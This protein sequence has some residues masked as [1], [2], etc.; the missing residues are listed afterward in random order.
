VTWPMIRALSTTTSERDIAT[1]PYPNKVVL[2]VTSLWMVVPVGWGLLQLA[3]PNPGEWV[4]T[5]CLALVCAASTAFWRDPKS[6][7]WLHKLDKGLA[8]VFMG[9]MGWYSRRELEALPLVVCSIVC[10]FLLS[11]HYFQHNMDAEQLAAHLMFRY[12]SYW[13]AYFCIVPS[14]SELAFT[15]MSVVY[16]SHAFLLYDGLERN[17]FQY[18]YCTHCLCMLFWIGACVLIVY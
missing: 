6:G 4:L 5:V 3:R 8:W 17:L 15:V 2:G 18:T 12:V 14:R 10:F 9:I 11:N 13:W 1:L 16:F 7:S